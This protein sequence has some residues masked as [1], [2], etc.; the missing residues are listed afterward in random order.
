MK[1][2]RRIVMLAMATFVLGTAAAAAQGMPSPPVGVWGCVVNSAPVT[3]EL[4]ME[5]A[6]NQSLFGRGTIVYNGTSA[7]YQVQGQGD[8]SALPPDQF[9]PHWN[10]KFRMFPSNHAIFSWFAGPT[11]SPNHLYNFFTNPQTGDQ[12]E[13]ACQRIG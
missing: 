3:I 5:V 4:Q 2:L 6:P 8:W 12:V 9:V 11:D 10:F 1:Y 13:T 7:I